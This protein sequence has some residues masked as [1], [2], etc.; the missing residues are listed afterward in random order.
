QGN[1]RVKALDL[2]SKGLKGTI[3][4]EVGNL[5]FLISLDI[6]NNNFQ[7]HIPDDLGHLCQLHGLY[8]QLNELSGQIPESSGFLNGIQELFLYNNS[9]TGPIPPAIFNI[10]SFQEKYQLVFLSV[11]KSSFLLYHTT[12]L[13]VQFLEKLGN[14]SRLEQ[15]YLGSNNLT[16]SLPHDICKKTRRLEILYLFVNQL[17]GQI[18]SSISG[19]RS[20]RQL[21]LTYNNISDVIPTEIGNMSAL[22]SLHLGSNN[23]TGWELPFNFFSISSLTHISLGINQFSG[24]LPKDI[25]FRHPNLEYLEYLELQSNQICGN[26]PSRLSLCSAL[27]DIALSTNYLTG[28]FKLPPISNTYSI[29]Q[30]GKSVFDNLCSEFSLEGYHL[31]LGTSQE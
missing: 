28:T 21:S 14:L 30:V 20:L 27:Y 31:K 4:K 16:G 6:I 24:N 22:Q 8:M 25:C 17:G 18:P 19:C 7:G 13:R 5:S 15:L 23:L 26:I 1:Q 9:L 11:L 10:S 29:A 12:N 2:S 3:A